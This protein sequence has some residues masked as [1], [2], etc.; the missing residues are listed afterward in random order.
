MKV[1]SSCGIFKTIY[2]NSS[3][4]LLFGKEKTLNVLKYLYNNNLSLKK[5]PSFFKLD[6]PRSTA[7]MT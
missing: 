6:P 1:T 7:P 2:H 4:V 5:V 3:Y